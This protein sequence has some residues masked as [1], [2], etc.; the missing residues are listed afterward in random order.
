M[1]YF[2]GHALSNALDD[3]LGVAIK[4]R[5][6]QFVQFILVGNGLEKSHL[7]N[8]AYQ[9][10]LENVTFLPP[11]SKLA[12]PNLV[13]YFDCCYVGAKNCSLYRFGISMNKIYDSMMSGKPLLYAINAPNNYAE[14]YQCGVSV[15]P[16]N[17]N[18]IEKGIEILMHMS[19]EERASMGNNGKHAVLEHFEYSIL[20]KQFIDAIM[21][22]GGYDEK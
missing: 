20:A 19:G 14:I 7:Q 16:G 11:V 10:N 9:E 6:N 17:V 21:I 3:L 8:I 1:G 4:M 13:Q 2:G 18:S 15:I 22:N 12:I 5:R